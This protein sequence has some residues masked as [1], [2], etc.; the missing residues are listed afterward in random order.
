MLMGNFACA[1][2]WLNNFVEWKCDIIKKIKLLIS[3]INFLFV[4]FNSFRL[5]KK[6]A[7][8]IFDE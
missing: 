6:S 2:T 8:K 4:L 3:G 1:K 5:E 7:N